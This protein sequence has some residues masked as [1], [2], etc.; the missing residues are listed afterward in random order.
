MGLRGEIALVESGGMR[1]LVGV[2]PSSMTTLAV[3]PEDFAAES[4]RE[5]AEE[6]VSILDRPAPKPAASPMSLGD[7]A[8][9]LFAFEGDPIKPPPARPFT[10]GAARYAEV[11]GDDVPAAATPRKPTRRA[12]SRENPIE[13]Q[14][15]GLALA[16]RKTR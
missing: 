4:E 7:R 9:S 10:I 5:R 1:V 11:A 3:L 12:A 8:R 13:G 14:A 16:L 6:R 2:T 15:R